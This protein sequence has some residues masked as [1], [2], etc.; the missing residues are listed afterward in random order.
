MKK[1]LFAL[2]LFVTVAGTT[3]A[4][5]FAYVDMEYILENTPSYQQA[6]SEINTLADQWRMEI[7][8]KMAEVEEAYK[9]FQ[10][11]QVLMTEQ[12]KQAKIQEIEELEKAAKELQK[13]K[14][15]PEGELFQKRQELIK[16]IQ[17]KIYEAIQFLAAERSYDFILDKSSGVQILYANEKYDKSDEI[18]KALKN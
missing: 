11:E 3:S 6:Q 16:P 9:K 12:M 8:E 14:F 17:D 13:Q 18:L 5:R 15:G 4:Q 1:I 10:A 7:S 2:I